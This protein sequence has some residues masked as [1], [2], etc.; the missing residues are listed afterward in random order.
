MSFIKKIVDDLREE[1]Y[2]AYEGTAQKRLSWRHAILESI[3]RP[4]VR[5]PPGKTPNSH[6]HPNLAKLH[7]PE[8]HIISDWRKYRVEDHPALVNF[9]KRCHAA[10]L[11]DPWLRNYA[12]AFYPSKM[13]R[14]S[15]LAFITTGLGFGII[16]GTS[17]FIAEK[18]YDH[19]FPTEYKHTPLYKGDGHGHDKHH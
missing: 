2:Q 4:T 8:G 1:A 13:E 6:P 9:Q 5:L 3:F 19:F 7:L 16:A 15:K 12:Y 11:H 17:L 14:R 18:I 10:G